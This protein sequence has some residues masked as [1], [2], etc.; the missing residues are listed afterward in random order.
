MIIQFRVNTHHAEKYFSV[1]CAFLQKVTDVFDE[2][3]ER[4]S[5]YIRNLWIRL[6]QQADRGAF[7]G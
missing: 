6:R 4:R 1:Y 7:D 2:F 3:V 5:I